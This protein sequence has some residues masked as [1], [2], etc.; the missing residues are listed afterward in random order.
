[1]KKIISQK[2]EPKDTS[3]IWLDT[4]TQQLRT[5]NNGKWVTLGTDDTSIA[6]LIKGGNPIQVPIKENTENIEDAYEPITP[7]KNSY[8][9]LP[10]HYGL[11]EVKEVFTNDI[12][13]PIYT[14]KNSIIYLLEANTEYKIIPSDLQELLKYTPDGIIYYYE[15]LGEETILNSITDKVYIYTDA[16]IS[17]Y[18][19]EE[20]SKKFQP[21]GACTRGSKIEFTDCSTTIA[22][23]HGNPYS[24]KFICEPVIIYS[25]KSKKFI[26]VNISGQWYLDELLTACELSFNFGNQ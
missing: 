3:V 13:K 10:G 4:N 20:A 17:T 24:G 2:T 19:S 15:T 7:T 26:T 23:V 11:F 21:L 22:A 5:Y 6:K 14:L 1:M 25:T 9:Y 18:A 12:Q 8:L 16:P